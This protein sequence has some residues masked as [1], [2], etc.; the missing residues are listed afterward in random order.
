ESDWA[1]ETSWFILDLSGQ[2]LAAYPDLIPIVE[3]V[4]TSSTSQYAKGTA[5]V[6]LGGSDLN[7][8][9]AL[10]FIKNAIELARARPD[11]KSLSD[12]RFQTAIQWA[13]QLGSHLPQAVQLLV[14]ELTVS[15]DIVATSKDLTVPQMVNLLC[16]I[17]ALGDVG[18]PAKTAIP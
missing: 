18:S 6:L 7:V 14:D 17:R 11:N 9:E 1:V 5:A 8:D 16:L 15:W 13:A 4:F 10:S 12:M 2:P 3:Q